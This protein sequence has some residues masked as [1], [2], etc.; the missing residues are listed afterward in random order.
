M[1]PAVWPGDVLF[2]RRDDA[3][4]ALPGDIVLFGRDG[5]FVAHRVVTVSKSGVRSPKSEVPN[6]TS[7]VFITRGDSL[8]HDD[9]PISRPEILGRVTAIE[10][11]SRQFTFRQT[12][13]SRLASRIL[14]RWDFATRAV[15]KIR[16]WGLYGTRDTGLETRNSRYR[17][18][19][20]LSRTSNL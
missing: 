2:V 20:P 16:G 10:R 4:E 7:R 5:R 3:A 1:L 6:P 12:F 13:A 19:Y 17:F 14:S 9:P 18:P 8:G 15:L 11:G